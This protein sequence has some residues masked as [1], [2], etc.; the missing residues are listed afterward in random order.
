MSVYTWRTVIPATAIS[1]VPL[2]EARSITISTQPVHVQFNLEV[3]QPSESATLMNSSISYCSSLAGAPT[4]THPKEHAHPPLLLPYKCASQALTALQAQAASA[5]C[6]SQVA[7][8]QAARACRGS[9]PS[10]VVPPRLPGASAP[11]IC[12]LHDTP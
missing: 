10:W 4:V 12:S 1:H 8:A 9:H 11:C 2:P 7:E 3:S 6:A 5:Q